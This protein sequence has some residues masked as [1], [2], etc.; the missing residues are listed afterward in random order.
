MAELQEY[1]ELHDLVYLWE[2]T[3]PSI[4]LLFLLRSKPQRDGTMGQGSFESEKN[5]GLGVSCLF[6]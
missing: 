3:G 1:V 6:P 2:G 4:K 5:L